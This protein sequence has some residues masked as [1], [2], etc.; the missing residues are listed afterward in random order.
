MAFICVCTYEEHINTP[1]FSIYLCCF[2]SKILILFSLKL[3][4]KIHSKLSYNF[5]VYITTNV[6]VLSTSKNTIQ[7][8]QVNI[9]RTKGNE[10][11][12]KY[13]FT[14]SIGILY[15]EIATSL[16]MKELLRK[17]E[18]IYVTKVPKHETLLIVIN[19]IIEHW[20]RCHY[21]ED[22]LFLWNFFSYGIFLPWQYSWHCVAWMYLVKTESTLYKF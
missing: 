22:T 3:S 9:L 10:Y 7:R 1:H 14:Q 20:W 15:S 12:S 16:P 8:K 2:S 11:I 17:L 18:L 19:S 6:T 4:F 5:K 21:M 13:W